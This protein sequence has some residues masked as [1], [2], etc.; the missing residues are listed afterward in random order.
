MTDFKPL[1]DELIEEE[2]RQQKEQKGPLSEEEVSYY[3]IV[4]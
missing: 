1:Q 3:S 4:L 2:E